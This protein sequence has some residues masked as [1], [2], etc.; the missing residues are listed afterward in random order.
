MPCWCLASLDIVKALS[1]DCILIMDGYKLLKNQITLTFDGALVLGHTV[2]MRT[3]AYTLPHI[4][5]SID[6]VVYFERNGEVRKFTSLPKELYGFA[7]I[8]LIDVERGS[9]KI[10]FVSELIEKV[11][12]LFN[13]FMGSPYEES[14]K[15]VLSHSK[16]LQADLEACKGMVFNGGVEEL[17]QEDLIAVE[18][19]RKRAYAQTAVL[20]DMNQALSLVRATPGAI[21]KLNIDSYDG[22]QEYVFDELRAARFGKVVATKRLDKPA[23]YIGRITGLEQQ[24]STAAFKYAAKFWSRVT[25]QENKLVI[26]EYDDAL[27]LHSHNLSNKD[28]AIWAA[29]ISVHETFDPVRGDLVFIDILS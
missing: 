7:D 18:G 8:Y 29:P 26:H 1:Y 3:L 20:K 4:Q 16:I 25:G 19:G 22:S 9:L 10:P 27:K 6:K 13:A 5:R 17:T 21:L 2:S 15:E 12:S 23:V 11:P 28:V 14:A 24:G